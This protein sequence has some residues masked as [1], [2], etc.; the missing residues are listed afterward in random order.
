MAEFQ[1]SDFLSF[2]EFPRA[3]DQLAVY[4]ATKE[5]L[6]HQKLFTKNTSVWEESLWSDEALENFKV[7]VMEMDRLYYMWY[8]RMW[9]DPMGYDPNRLDRQLELVGRMP[10]RGTPTYFSLYTWTD[11]VKCYHKG[12]FIGKIFVSQNPNIFM[13]LVV[14][15]SY[16][17][18][19]IYES[20]ANDGIEMEP[21]KNPQYWKDNRHETSSTDVSSLSSCCQNAIIDGN[22][23]RD[24]YRY[25]LP[26]RVGEEVEELQT[27]R[28]FLEDR[29][30]VCNGYICSGST[31]T[32]ESICPA[33]TERREVD[34]EEMSRI[35]GIFYNQRS[36]RSK[37]TGGKRKRS[38][39][40]SAAESAAAV[41]NRPL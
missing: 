19:D 12:C 4:E 23:P 20:L 18:E 28:Y 5:V 34:D 27:Y 40:I 38:R 16:P 21:Y 3:S 14:N 10:Y 41:W 35:E 30:N 13:P 8:D 1:G 32:H 22:I 25:Q 9:F 7:S 29:N 2:S 33:Y 26:P 17:I 6:S 36:V 37:R 11:N 15:G 39:K 31:L 24:F